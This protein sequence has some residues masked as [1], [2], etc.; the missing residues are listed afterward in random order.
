M[1]AGARGQGFRLNS[2]PKMRK[3]EKIM[4]VVIIVIVIVIVPGILIAIL[5]PKPQK[6]VKY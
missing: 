3:V 4:N 5:I 2:L 6:Y 1:I